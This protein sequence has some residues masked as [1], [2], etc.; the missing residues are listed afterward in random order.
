MLIAYVLPLICHIKKT[1]EF[2]PPQ[3]W[4]PNSPD[5]NPV[6]NSMWELLQE[7]YKILIT[8][9]ELSTSATDEWLPQ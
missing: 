7:V 6:D 5:M 2:I 1:P 8:D 3:L 4:P 9:L